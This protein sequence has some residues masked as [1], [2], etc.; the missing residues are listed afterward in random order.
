MNLEDPKSAQVSLA[1]QDQAQSTRAG[2]GVR[3]LC[4]FPVLM[5]ALL[6]AVVLGNLFLGLKAAASAPAGKASYCVFEGDTWWHVAVGQQILST[7][8]WPTKDNYSFSAAGNPWI[9]TEW[10]GEVAMAYSQAK[11]GLR[12]LGLLLMT[13]A[14]A[15]IVLIYIYAYVKSRN[16]KAAFAAC[17]L[18]LPLIIIF[19]NLRPQLLGYIFLLIT[20]I[21]LESFRQGRLKKLWLLPVVFLL[22]VNTHGTFAL[23]FAIFALYWAGGTVKLQFGTLRSQLW[24]AA[25]RRHLEI[26]GLLSLLASLITPYGTRLFSFPLQMALFQPLTMASFQE[27]KPPDFGG[28]YGKYFLLILLVLLVIHIIARMEYR[29]EEVGLLLL[30]VYGA[31]MHTRMIVFFVMIAAGVLAQVFA[32]YI[33]GYEAGKDKY[34]LNAALIALIV[35]G[36]VKLFPSRAEMEEVVNHGFPQGAAAYL[37]RHPTLGPTFDKEFWGGYLIRELGPRQRVFIDGRGDL[38]EPAG[39]LAD[40]LNIMSVVPDTPFLLRKYRINACLIEP[41]SPLAIFLARSPAWTRAYTGPLSVVFVRRK[42]IPAATTPD[43][44]GSRRGPK[45]SR[46][47]RTTA[48]MMEPGDFP[49]RRMSAW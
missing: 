49:R 10:L 30:A 22:W 44:A 19:F 42:A 43:Q 33:P 31:C 21:G 4:S 7:H 40:Y 25:E 28:S 14:S 18:M 24:S 26:V 23:G 27:W 8:T 38:Y 13:F 11:G 1:G 2:L 46:R 9:A 35:F 41:Q 15:I 47:N 45:G 6:V 34:F 3:R 37:R 12:G 17:A 16:A 29:L 39:V 48:C 32:R 36:C 5:G 20:L